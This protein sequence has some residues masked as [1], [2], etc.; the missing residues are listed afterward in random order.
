VADLFDVQDEIVA[1]LAGRRCP[2]EGDERI[3]S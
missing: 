3:A 2:A 1:R